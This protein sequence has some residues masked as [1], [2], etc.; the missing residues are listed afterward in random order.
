MNVFKRLA[1]AVL[2]SLEDS[3]LTF[4]DGST[5]EILGTSTLVVSHQ[6]VH[7]PVCFVVV[8]TVSAALAADILL[9]TDYMSKRSQSVVFKFPTERAIITQFVSAALT[10]VPNNADTIQGGDFTLNRLP[11]GSWELDWQW[12][13]E[14]PHGLFKGV[15]VYSRKLKSPQQ[16]DWF[17]TEVK[18]WVDSKFLVPFDSKIF[19]EKRCTLTWN[20]VVQTHKNTKVRPTLDY[21]ILNPYIKNHNFVSQS[22]ICHEALRKWRRYKTAYL[23]DVEKAYM[24][25]YVS[26]KLYPYQV[27]QVDQKVYAMTRM[28][29][30]LNI[31]PRVLKC[32][33]AHVLDKAA[34][35]ATVSPYRDD[36]LVGSG[37]ATPQGRQT[38]LEQVQKV[39]DLLL[40]HGLPTKSPVDLFDFSTGP[41]RALGLELFSRNG[42]IWWRRRGDSE[43]KL[44]KKDPKCRDIAAFVGRACP[45][46]YPVMGCIRPIALDI[47]SQTGREAHSG[48]WNALA[49]PGLIEKARILEQQIT[50][51]DPVQGRWRI[52]VTSEWVLA[53]DASG[54]ALGCCVLTQT[55]WTEHPQ[56]DCAVIE[57]HCWLVKKL[58]T[59]INVLELDAVILGIK[60]ISGYVNPTDHILFLIDNLVVVNWLKATLADGKIEV[61]GLYEILVR[62]RLRIVQELVQPYKVEV[63][64]IASELNPAD[65]LTRSPTR[66]VEISAATEVAPTP[67]NP[68]LEQIRSSQ[69]E[70]DDTRAIIQRL[71][72]H[73]LLVVRNELAYKKLHLGREVLLQ[74]V[75]A[76]ALAK[77]VIRSVHEEISHAGWK[78]TWYTTKK[79]YYF[80]KNVPLAAEVQKFLRECS[81]CSIK[82]AKICSTTADRHSCRLRPW[83]EVFVDTLQLG[84]VSDASPH[85]VVVFIDN[86]SKF[87]E[88]FI[89]ANKSAEEICAHTESVIA[90]YGK[91]G[92]LR[93]D[94]GREFDNEKMRHLANRYGFTLAYGS[95]RNP[96]SQ[97]T[98]ERLH[99]T[100]LGILRALLFGTKNHWT[101]EFGRALSV[102]RSRPHASLGNRSPREVLFGEP[103]V[104]TTDDF[105]AANYQADAFDE[106]D[107]RER[108]DELA[109]AELPPRFS[110]G[111][112]VLVRVD[113][114]R[115][116][117][118][119]YPWVQ[120]TIVRVIGHGAYLVRDDQ[121]RQAM[122]N[123]KSLAKLAVSFPVENFHE[124]RP[125]PQEVINEPEVEFLTP[126]QAPPS[127]DQLERRDDSV[128]PEDA[129]SAPSES[130]TPEPVPMAT[131]PVRGSKR[132]RRPVRR[133]IEEL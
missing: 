88:A 109:Q 22:E 28:G 42:E 45:A 53:T 5:T 43:W 71:D 65:K 92:T 61:S 32:L 52:P 4:V 35:D 30:G 119:E 51:A 33:I 67:S 133:L 125:E 24:N 115:R 122:F 44:T 39:R 56:S 3:R 68:L 36:I 72:E 40:S 7:V 20:P 23:V 114:R 13:R 118:L 113:D 78:A 6:A 70:D 120:G 111:E 10:N 91:I 69:I 77:E 89:L 93:L 60:I 46:S 101:T 55:D 34:L 130:R 62:R 16:V 97:A 75:V 107:R 94:N 84:S 37:D 9:G 104:P 79:R 90:R 80:G 18:K 50:A 25:V 29:F 1:G 11:S 74:V 41:T 54:Q 73:G 59:H 15:H 105:N 64:W 132:I 106:I 2:S 27:V 85:S 86:Y 17:N 103:E 121:G 108:R 21:A 129:I 110:T 95:I 48:G 123:E 82:N 99:S 63:R 96:Q 8:N 58:E 31:A 116:V 81:V 38:V 127:P 49:S 100:L 87:C 19:G 98:V 26:P 47:L 76:S 131:P 57:D 14:P 128:S 124:V 66:S 126:I 102:Y 112:R 83:E 12:D 117:K